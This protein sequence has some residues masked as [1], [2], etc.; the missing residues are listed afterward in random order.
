MLGLSHTDFIPISTSL[1]NDSRLFCVFPFLLSCNLKLQN[2]I[3]EYKLL[4]KWLYISLVPGYA[5]REAEISAAPRNCWFPGNLKWSNCGSCCGIS[6]WW[7]TTKQH[8]Y[9]SYVFIILITFGSSICR[10]NTAKRLCFSGLKV[11]C[12]GNFSC[13]ANGGS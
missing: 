13:F 5:T 3:T 9:T 2:V 7:L 6:H 12:G 8:C 10:W 1:W 11:L 4:R